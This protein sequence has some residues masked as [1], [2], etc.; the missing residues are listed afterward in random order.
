MGNGWF[1]GESAGESDGWASGRDPGAWHS[2][3]PVPRYR[4][5]GGPSNDGK[6]KAKRRT[7]AKAARATRKRQRRAKA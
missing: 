3:P 4:S 6:T 7:Q 1:S 5:D 2:R